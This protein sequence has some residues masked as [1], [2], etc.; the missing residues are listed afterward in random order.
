VHARTET[1]WFRPV[2]ARADAILFLFQ[3]LHFHLPDGARQPANS[4][5]PVVLIAFGPEDAA[6]LRASR[7]PGAFVTCWEADTR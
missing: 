3:R 1:D 4:G 7:I 2:W 5:A 6:A